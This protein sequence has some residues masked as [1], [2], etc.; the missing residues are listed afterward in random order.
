MTRPAVPISSCWCGAAMIASCST[1]QVQETRSPKAQQATGRGAGRTHSRPA[2]A[3]HPQLSVQPD[4]DHRRL[5]D[6]VPRRPHHLRPEPARRLPRAWQR[7]P[8][9]G[10]APVRDQRAVRAATSTAWSTL[11]P[12]MGGGPAS[13]ARSFPTPSRTDASAC[14]ARRAAR[15]RPRVMTWRRILI[16]G[17]S[18]SF[19]T[20]NGSSARMKRRTF[21][22]T[23]SSALTRS[24]ASDSAFWSSPARRIALRTRFM[25]PFGIGDDQ[26]DQVRPAVAVRPSPGRFRAAGSACPRPAAARHC[27]PCR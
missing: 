5:D 2:G 18:C 22:I 11:S 14:R 20:V 27:R 19:S 24:T 21:S 9:I 3:L 16:D 15:H 4:A 25:R 12:S 13:S 26:G 7:Q 1:G 8:H 23:D 10:H 6:P 17:V